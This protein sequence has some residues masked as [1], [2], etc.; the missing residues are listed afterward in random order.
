MI[1]NYC[2]LFQ[3]IAV[4][5]DASKSAPFG[6]GAFSPAH[7]TKPYFIP[8][9]ASPAC[10]FGKVLTADEIKQRC[11]TFVPPKTSQCNRW[12]AS[13]YMQWVRNS[14]PICKE[15][16]PTDLLSSPYDYW[17]SAFVLEARRKDGHYYPPNTIR[18]ILAALYRTMKSHLGPIYQASWI[19]AVVSLLPYS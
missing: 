4:F 5:V 13:V 17:L 8:T 2:P 7:N 9:T 18:N 12:T 19:V 1:I 16:C 11:Q 6:P 14:D 10:R 3:V 15:R